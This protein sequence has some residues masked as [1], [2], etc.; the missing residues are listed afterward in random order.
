MM[1][2]A[3]LGHSVILTPTNQ[4]NNMETV[5]IQYFGKVYSYPLLTAEDIGVDRIVR[6][7]NFEFSEQGYEQ[8]YN[9]SKRFH[10]VTTKEE[11]VKL[12]ELQ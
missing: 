3:I 12:K 4:E 6:T 8:C 9:E 1:T 5:T 2:L 10:F 7:F 11:L